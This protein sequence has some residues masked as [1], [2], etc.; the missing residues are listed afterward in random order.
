M[1]ELIDIVSEEASIMDPEDRSEQTTQNALYRAA[2][3][4]RKIRDTGHGPTLNPTE[5]E[6]VKYAL[7]DV[8]E[9]YLSTGEKKEHQSRRQKARTQAEVLGIYL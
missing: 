6:A 1:Q 2:T 7:E 4:I 9:L 3:K 8:G 5:K